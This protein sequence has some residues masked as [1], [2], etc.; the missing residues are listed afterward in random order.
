MLQLLQS[1]WYLFSMSLPANSAGCTGDPIT[2]D[3]VVNPEPNVDQPVSQ[4]LCVGEI[5]DVDF[6]YNQ[7]RRNFRVY[8]WTNDNSSIGLPL[9]GSGDISEYSQ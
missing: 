9:T 3:V 1:Q 7:Y 2:F 5:L 6:V 8:M 4:I